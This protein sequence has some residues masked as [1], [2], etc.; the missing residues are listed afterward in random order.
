M[1]DGLD[2][3]V[4]FERVVRALAAGEAPGAANPVYQTM[5]VL[6]PALAA[7]D[8]DW[9]MHQMEGEI[10]NAVGATKLDLELELDE[11]PDGHLA[12]RLI[13]D[14]DLFEPAT[15]ARVVDHFTRA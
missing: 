10:G 15:A 5:L 9:S 14:R 12:G 7:P 3:V 13:Y 6:E 1:L 11:R 2:N 8:P 4:P